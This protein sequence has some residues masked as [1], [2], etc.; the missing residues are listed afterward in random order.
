MPSPTLYAKVASG[1]FV[2]VDD[3]LAVLQCE[4]AITDFRAANGISDSI[5]KIDA[6]AVYWKKS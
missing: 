3:Y 6:A 2:I 5:H 4:R 1:G